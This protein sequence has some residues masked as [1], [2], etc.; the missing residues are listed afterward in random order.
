MAAN[1]LEGPLPETSGRKRR[2]KPGANT[3]LA[4][5]P[6][7]R[8][9]RIMARRKASLPGVHGPQPINAAMRGT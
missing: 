4:T 1:A 2:H 8:C 6:R 5:S 7:A 9:Q 3:P